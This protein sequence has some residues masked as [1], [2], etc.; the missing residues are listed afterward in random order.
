[1]LANC[2]AMERVEAFRKEVIRLVNETTDIVTFGR[3]MR[4]LREKDVSLLKIEPLTKEMHKTRIQESLESLEKGLFYTSEEVRELFK[5]RKWE[6][7][8]PIRSKIA[9]KKRQKRSLKTSKA[10]DRRF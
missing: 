7:L 5:F 3:V 1:M 2:K 10:P 9:T 8:P 6:P 4:I